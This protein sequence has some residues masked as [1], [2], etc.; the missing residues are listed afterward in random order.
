MQPQ[1]QVVHGPSE[2]DFCDCILG[3]VMILMVIYISFI[4]YQI[5][6]GIDRAYSIIDVKKSAFPLDE[7]VTIHVIN[8]GNVDIT[9]IDQA[10]DTLSP[11]VDLQFTPDTSADICI[12]VF[13]ADMLVDTQTAETF[14]GRTYYPDQNR[15][16]AWPNGC[17]SYSMIYLSR[18]SHH[19]PVQSLHELMHAL[20]I[21]DHSTDPRDIMYPTINSQQNGLTA[22][23]IARLKA[24]YP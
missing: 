10:V 12:Y 19:G 22:G 15:K 20:G 16:I 2:D 17:T 18:P 23:D 3:F 11:Y 9:L 14:A 6:V 5:L 7:P 13:A 8:E 21:K 4:G 1:Q 24:L